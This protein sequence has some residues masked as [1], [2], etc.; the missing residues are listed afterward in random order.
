MDPSGVVSKHKMVIFLYN[1]NFFVWI[2][3]SCLANTV[4][5]LNPSNSAIMRLRKLN[6]SCIQQIS[7]DYIEK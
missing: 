3:H 6:N 1:L 4:F 5:G 7:I 2:Q